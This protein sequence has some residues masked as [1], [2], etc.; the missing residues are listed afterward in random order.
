MKKIAS[1]FILIFISTVSLSAQVYFEE[2]KKDSTTFRD[3]LYFGGNLSLNLGFG[4]GSTFIDI[5][6]LAGYMINEK[7]SVGLG[8]TYLYVSREFILL[9][10]NDRFRVSNSVYGGRTFLRHSILDNYFLHTEFET[11][12]T[13]VLVNDT[14][15]DTA[16]EWVPGFFIGGGTFQPVFSRGGINISILYN[17]LYDEIRSPYG[18]AWVVRGGVTF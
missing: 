4:G 14:N 6:P 18:S 1:I 15:G 7:L 5:S 3:R 17:L 8:A 12:N 9:P 2:D 10:S 11:L 16:R 13:K